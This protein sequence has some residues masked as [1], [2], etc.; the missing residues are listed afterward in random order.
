MLNKNNILSSKER[1]NRPM[2]QQQ[3]YTIIHNNN[4]RFSADASQLTPK[5]LKH[6]MHHYKH[7]FTPYTMKVTGIVIITIDILLL[8]I[9]FAGSIYNVS[10]LHVDICYTEIFIVHFL[11][12]IH[13]ALGMCISQ[14]VDGIMKDSESINN[15]SKKLLNYYTP[16]SWSFTSLVSLL[17]DVSLLA[18]AI[19]SHIIVG[20]ADVCKTS[21]I[22]HIA[23][24][25][26]AVIISL[27]SITW[28]IVFASYTLDHTIHLNKEERGDGEGEHHHHHH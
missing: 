16:L 18:Y 11:I 20:D 23:Y 14:I 22:L 9:W 5:Q 27:T 19:R 21:R 4:H 24:D 12:L 6:H 15:E 1:S 13:F 28:F 25:V 3:Q 8:L 2:K 26:I 17:G 7:I 10:Q